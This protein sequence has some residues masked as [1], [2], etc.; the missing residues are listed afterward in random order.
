MK[1]EV[2]S[3]IACPFCYIGKRRIEAGLEQFVHKDQVQIVYKSFQLNENAK[4]DTEYDAYDALST[5]SGMSREA[6]KEIHERL[7]KQ[8]EVDGLDLRFDTLQLTNTLDAHRLLHFAAQHGK[9]NE[10]AELLFKVYFTECKHVGRHETLIAIAAEVGLDPKAA[11]EML[12]SEQFTDEVRADHLEGIRLGVSGVPFYV[13]DRKY[14]VS[15]AQPANVFLEAL[16]KT[17]AESQSLAVLNPTSAEA[18][19]VCENGVCKN[20]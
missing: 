8:A 18:G 11:E 17:W 4:K 12:T 10:V 13:I 20:E 16:E 5:R 6:A 2:W 19:P 15:G 9:N 3:D 7:A 14:V 1:V